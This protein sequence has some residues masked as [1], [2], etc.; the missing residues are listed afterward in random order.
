MFPTFGVAPANWLTTWKK[1]N[2]SLIPFCPHCQ[3]YE[4]SKALS[5]NQCFATTEERAVS[6]EIDIRAVDKII[7]LRARTPPDLDRARACV[8]KL[9]LNK[10]IS[11]WWLGRGVTGACVHKLQ[12]TSNTFFWLERRFDRKP[13]TGNCP[14]VASCASVCLPLSFYIHIWYLSLIEELFWP[15]PLPPAPLALACSALRRTTRAPAP[16]PPQGAEGGISKDYICSP[17]YATN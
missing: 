13:T 4:A 11:S 8:N 3:R 1:G 10:T 16:S 17:W 15:V 12:A 2:F 6:K 14:L 7:F 9:Q 5:K